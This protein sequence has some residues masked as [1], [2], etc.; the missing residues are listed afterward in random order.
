MYFLVLLSTFPSAGGLASVREF[1]G[2]RHRKNGG[3]GLRRPQCRQAF[4]SR[5][6]AVPG[7]RAMN[8]SPASIHKPADAIRRRVQ[9]P[10]PPGSVAPHD[11]RASDEIV[12]A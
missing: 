1:H 12:R 11:D 2:R 4:A 7:A 8:K 10:P 3:I 5:S 6:E 9:I